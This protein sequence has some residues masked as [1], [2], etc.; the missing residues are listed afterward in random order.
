M[1]TYGVATTTI[2][3]NKLQC[4]VIFLNGILGPCQVKQRSCACFGYYNSTGNVTGC[5]RDCMDN[6]SCVLTKVLLCGQF[7]GTLRIRAADPYQYNLRPLR[8]HSQCP[9]NSFLQESNLLILSFSCLCEASSDY[10]TGTKMLAC[11]TEQCS[12]NLPIFMQVS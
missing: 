3:I 12:P 7:F 10:N 4:M 8:V 2:T 9:F 6:K 5:C 11:F 1:K